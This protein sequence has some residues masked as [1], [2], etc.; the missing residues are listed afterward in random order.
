MDTAVKGAQ[1]NKTAAK[2]EIIKLEKNTDKLK[3]N[4][5]GKLRNL[6]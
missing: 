2:A 1:E 4:E 5:E 3:N 6:M